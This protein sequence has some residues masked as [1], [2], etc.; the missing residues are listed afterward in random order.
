MKKSTKTKMFHSLFRRYMAKESTEIGDALKDPWRRGRRGDW[1]S[2]RTKE[3]VRGLPEGPA[4]SVDE[5]LATV[6]NVVGDNIE[7]V[8][9]EG[10]VEGLEEGM[11][12]SKGR[13]DCKLEG[14]NFE[15]HDGAMVLGK[16]GKSCMGKGV[17]NFRYFTCKF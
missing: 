6:G 8:V 10:E 12:D 15:I 3:E 14:A 7:G 11:G 9:S 13:D 17:L 5:V 16:G 1:R 2:K 4:V